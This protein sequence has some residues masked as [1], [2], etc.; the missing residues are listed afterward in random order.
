MLSL[1]ILLEKRTPELETILE[2]LKAPQPPIP[3]TDEVDAFCTRIGATLRRLQY[4]QR[5]E[6]EIKILQL[7]YDYEHK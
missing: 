6:A 5:C 1:L 3:E 4:R 2:A 7:L